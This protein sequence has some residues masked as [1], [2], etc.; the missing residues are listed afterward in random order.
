MPEARRGDLIAV[1]TTSRDFL[2]G[3]GAYTTT[4][5]RVGTI[6]SV[7]RNGLAKAWCPI[8]S[9][10][11]RD[12]NPVREKWKL[13]EADRVRVEGV[14]GMVR[15]HTHPG[16]PFQILPFTSETELRE[17]LQPHLKRHLA[18]VPIVTEFT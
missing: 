8:G 6:T 9:T 14:I 11:P 5:V 18:G 16:D 2:V 13:I 4:A 12:L 3:K 10:T 15:A 17:A 7:T 1:T